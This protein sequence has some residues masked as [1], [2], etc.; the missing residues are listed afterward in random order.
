LRFPVPRL[1]AASP[2]PALLLCAF[3][4]NVASAAEVG[5]ATF[6]DINRD[7]LMQPFEEAAPRQGGTRLRWHRATDRPCAD[8]HDRALHPDLS[9]GTGQWATD[10]ATPISTYLASEGLRVVNSYN[11]VVSAW[12]VCDAPGLRSATRL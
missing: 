5:G 9:A 4:A 1:V 7:G 10:V 6:K 2:R 8:R 3:G 11:D 12:Q